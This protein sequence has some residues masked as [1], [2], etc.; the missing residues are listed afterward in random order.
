[1]KPK[2]R[3]DIKSLKGTLAIL[4]GSSNTRGHIYSIYVK[5]ESS[6]LEVLRA[7]IPAAAFG[8]A[9]GSDVECTFEVRDTF[10]LLGTRA[11]NKQVKVTVPYARR[12]WARE[13]RRRGTREARSRW[14]DGLP[15]GHRQPTQCGLVGPYRWR[16]DRRQGFILQACG[17]GHREGDRTMKAAKELTIGEVA[18]GVPQIGVVALTIAHFMHAGQV[19]KQGE[20]YLKHLRAVAESFPRDSDEYVVGWLHDLL[21][22]TDATALGLAYAGIPTRLIR[23]VEALTKQPGET[24]R[25]YIDRIIA[26]PEPDVRD[27]AVAVKRADLRHNLRPGF[28]NGHAR[29]L[30]ALDR[31]AAAFGPDHRDY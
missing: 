11:E 1:M 10:D 12:C 4:R 5:D 22:D 21:E 15:A 20:P 16:R 17:P 27:I 25:T 30:E 18:E 24:Y 2:R 23:A 19:D 26:Y 7:E 3:P 8:E 29:Y 9:L 28:P 13:A 14:L 6:R 31:F